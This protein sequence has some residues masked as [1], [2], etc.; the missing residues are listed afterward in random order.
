MPKLKPL[1]DQVIVITGASSG[2]GLC[3]ARMA[4]AKGARVVLAARNHE[5]LQRVV[6]EIEAD[7]G[8]AVAVVAD[9]GVTEQV[10]RI[11]DIARER[12]GGF[13]TWVNVAGVGIW[14]RLNE[15]EEA[16]AR[17]LFDTNYWGLVHGSLVAAR[18][19]KGRGG[20]AIINIG[21]VASDIALPLQGMYSASKHAV[22]GFTDT[23]RMELEEEGAPV[24]VTLI[25][26]ASVGTPM[27]QHF[28]NETGRKGT[29]PPPV[30]APEEVAL[31]ILYAATHPTRDIRVGSASK[32]MGGMGKLTPR[33]FDRIG[34]R[35]FVGAQLKDAPAART[36]G[37][38]YKPMSG[39]E[40][41]GEV[42]GHLI[43]PS[44]YTRAR[45]HPVI[46]GGALL[47][48]VLTGAALMNRKSISRTVRTFSR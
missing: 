46:T 32:A 25:K 34:E 18:H 28:K 12:F 47:A 3:T 19:L 16:D 6:G 39:G 38:L 1:A 14:G 11:A 35:I 26:P 13:D 4:A 22:K 42:D 36:Q 41:R 30:Y 43:R 20:G 23:L 10:Q 9:V 37:N 33:L 8:E 21:S 15:V 44:L 45:L 29:F 2:I 31:S 27:P 5:A 24:A 48:G 40:E 17:R 7:G